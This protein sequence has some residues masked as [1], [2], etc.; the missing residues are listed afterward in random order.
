MMAMRLSWG[1]ELMNISCF[2]K[3]L[4]KFLRFLSEGAN[5]IAGDHPR[6]EDGHW[7]AMKLIV[8]IICDFNQQQLSGLTFYSANYIFD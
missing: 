7:A 1:L 6:S 5:R 3:G 2:I 4:A 8:E